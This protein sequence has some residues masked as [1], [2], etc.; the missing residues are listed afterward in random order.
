MPRKPSYEEL[1]K[2][3]KQLE[4]EAA[5]R[6]QVE[7]GLQK[8]THELG[9]RVKELNCLYG[10]SN[11]VE[12]PDISLNEI[13]RSVVN[14]IPPSWQYPE[15]T[16]SR[17][18]LE[19]QE[20]RTKNFKDTIWKQACD[21]I[22]HGE[23]IGTLDVCYLE[24]RPEGDEGPFL[25]EERSLLNAIS[26]QLGRITERMRMEEHIHALAQQM[27]KAQEVERQMIFHELHDCV[28]QDISTLKIES[29]ILFD[30]LPAVPRE[31]RQKV[32]KFTEILR[33]VIMAIRNLSYKLRPPGLDQ[34]GLVKT[35]FQYCEDFSKKNIVNVDFYTAGMDGLSFDSDIGINLFRLIQEGLNNIKKYTDASNV[36][37]R[38]VASS[39]NIILRIEDD[40]KGFDLKDK[41][42]TALNEKWMGLQS[43]QERVCM[44]QGKM[45]VKSLPMGGTRI[46]IELPYQKNNS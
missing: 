20:F 36:T 14:L 10:I 31:I 13:L 27:L 35:V 28:A 16:C 32:S 17:L 5:K 46:V 7:E 12:E 39:P 45:T 30:N 41:L 9:E 42:V 24:E 6:K 40:G 3:V 38:I 11:L 22:V 19:G 37:I 4:I 23:R 1:E 2:R 44:L 34:L 21:I 29:E 8:R 33:G 18:I 25:K 26:E 43:M 15:I